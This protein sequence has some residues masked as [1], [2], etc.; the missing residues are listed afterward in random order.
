MSATL[1]GVIGGASVFGGNLLTV[2]VGPTYNAN[3]G[4]SYQNILYSSVITTSNASS[5]DI[6]TGQFTLNYTGK[7]LLNFK[8]RANT[9]GAGVYWS[10]PMTLVLQITG[11]TNSMGG[12]QFF[13]TYGGT[14]NGGSGTLS[15]TQI[16]E[17]TTTGQT[18]YMQLGQGQ[19][20]GSG[21]YPIAG[22]IAQG[23]RS[24][25]LYLGQ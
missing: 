21:F 20:Y 19:T 3:P 9:N 16:I 23:S 2:I 6:T 14:S 12:R 24:T 4:A 13:S 10:P 25:I 5:L 8:V 22:S 17:T 18:F 1:S 15:W 11:L 7:Y